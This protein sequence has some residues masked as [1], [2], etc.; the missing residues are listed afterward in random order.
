MFSKTVLS[1]FTR[2]KLLDYQEKH[3]LNLLDIILKKNIAVDLSDAG[4]GKTYTSSALCCELK[5]KPIIFCPKTL[6]ANW[7]R[8][9]NLFGVEY[10]DIVNYETIKNGKTYTDYECKKR[11]KAPYIRLIDPNPNDPHRYEYLWNLPNDAIV[12][13]DEVHKCKHGNTEN[14]K[15]LLSTK[16]FINKKIP[17][18]MLSATISEKIKDLQIP[19][20]LFGIIP[21]ISNFEHYMKLVINKYPKYR[22]KKQDYASLDEFKNA[23]KNSKA[24]II[25]EEN[26][27]FTSRIRIKD[28]GDKFPKI[29]QDVNYL[30]QTMHLMRLIL[31][32]HMLK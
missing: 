22:V 6:I 23:Q 30:W 19:F 20:F 32:T 7:R 14:G 2:G 1:N 29:R 9:L 25:H 13:F 5:K 21:K 28:L 18:L 4:I 26:K 8:V 31:Q 24:M 10:Y 12:I 27:E 16:Q 17:L 11:V 15:L 3:V